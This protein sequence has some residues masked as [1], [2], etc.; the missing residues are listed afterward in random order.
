MAQ[1]RHPAAIRV[2]AADGTLLGTRMTAIKASGLPV[3]AS[4][5]FPN[6]APSLW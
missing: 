3:T 6:F 2:L 1:L 4:Y 5:A